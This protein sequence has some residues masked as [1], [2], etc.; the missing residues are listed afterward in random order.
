[1]ATATPATRAMRAARWMRPVRC[2]RLINPSVAFGFLR[3][4][5]GEARVRRRSAA[6]FLSSPSPARVALVSATARKRTG[7]LNSGVGSGRPSCVRGGGLRGLDAGGRTR[8]WGET[9]RGEGAVRE[10]RKAPNRR[11]RVSVHGRGVEGERAC[12]AAG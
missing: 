10:P 4:G 11:R 8:A 6:A 2:S 7:T 1:V 5:E 9:V 3:V 12:P